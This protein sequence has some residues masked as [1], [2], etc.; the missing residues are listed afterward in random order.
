MNSKDTTLSEVSQLHKNKQYVIYM[1]KFIEAESRIVVAR[2]REM[3][4]G[5]NGELLLEF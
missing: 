2:D 5:G 3:G 4:G 1:V